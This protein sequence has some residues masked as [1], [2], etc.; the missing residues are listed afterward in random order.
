MELSDDTLK[1]SIS[2]EKTT[3]EITKIEQSTLDEE[4]KQ[5]SDQ[6]TLT[7]TAT[8]SSTKPQNSAITLQLPI[9]RVKKIIKLDKDVNKFTSDSQFSIAK[10]TE[11]F[12]EYFVTEAYKSTK[13]DGRKILQYRD[14]AS[15]VQDMD[16]LEF[17]SD[18]IP[19]KK[20]S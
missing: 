16:N 14:L 10:A 11:L 12:L 2:E 1:E 3:N 4:P 15:C 18:I 9:A 8:K 5:Q 20:T 7:K 17:L 6:S 19:E 13:R